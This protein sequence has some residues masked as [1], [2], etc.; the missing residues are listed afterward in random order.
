MTTLI[1]FDTATDD[2]AVGAVRDGEP[3]YSSSLEAPEDGRP[4]HATRL[5]A[6]V[7]DAAR[8]AGGW[9]SVTRIA[10]RHRAGLVHRAADR[11]RDRERSW[12]GARDRRSSASARLEAL[13][14]GAG[15]GG[16]AVLALLD[17]R[18]GE[19]FA[20]PAAAPAGRPLWEPFVAAPGEV[21][22]RVAELRDAPLAV[23]S[24]ALRFRDELEKG[25]T[26]VAPDADPAHRIDGLQVC[27]AAESAVEGPVA[28]VYLRPPDAQRWHERDSTDS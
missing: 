19:V 3:T 6:E 8:A 15:A 25:G 10:R 22:S 23:G 18:R 2:T 14:R 12:P 7:E 5:L 26:E 28:P 1:G 20:S 24:G 4:L 13:A 17:A 16:R 9:E 21:A 11:D 27:A